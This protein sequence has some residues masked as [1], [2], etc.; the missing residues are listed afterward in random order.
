MTAGTVVLGLNEKK[1]VGAHGAGLPLTAFE[2]QHEGGGFCIDRYQSRGRA[3]PGSTGALKTSGRVLA[4][5]SQG[6]SKS[7]C[8]RSGGGSVPA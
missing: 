6:G 5:N 7:S 1:I 4:E 2:I 8:R 3:E